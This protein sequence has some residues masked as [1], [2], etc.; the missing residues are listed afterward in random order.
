[1]MRLAMAREMGRWGAFVLARLVPTMVVFIISGFWHGAGWTFVVWGVM[2]GC[3]VSTQEFWSELF[4]KNRKKN[5]AKKPTFVFRYFVLTF[6][7][8]V[9]SNV[10]FRAIS[11]PSAL[12]IYGGMLNLASMIDGLRH[13]FEALDQTVPA[14]AV[15]AVGFA[16]IFLAPNSQQIMR[17]YD[18]ALDW[19]T[20]RKM[21]IPLPSIEWRPNLGYAI[22]TGLTL[23]FGLLFIVRGQSAF[24]YFNF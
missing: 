17:R 20:W 5:K 2:H 4:K 23:A 6:L 13:G 19:Q 15:I 12:N 7:A 21:P 16:I 3:Y 14:L 22:V 10:M 18:P 1:M 8:V 11:V 9:A 24:I